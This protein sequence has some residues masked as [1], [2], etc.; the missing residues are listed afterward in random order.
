[1]NV[2]FFLYSSCIFLLA[3]FLFMVLVWRYGLRRTLAGLGERWGGGPDPDIRSLEKRWV[4]VH[5][6][7]VGEVRAVG[8]FLRRFPE[9]FPGCGRLLTTTTVAGRDLARAENLAES[10]VLAPLDVPWAVERFLTRWSPTALVLVETELWP[11]W[12]RAMAARRLPMLL[13][14]GRISARSFPGYYA[15]RFLWTPLLKR[16]SRIAVQGPRQA[17]RFLRL[18]APADRVVIAGNL[19][20]DVAPPG[21]PRGEALMKRFGFSPGDDV[22]VCGSTHPGEES[23]VA[24]AY[25]ALRRKGRFF[26]VAVA[27]RHV[28]R[29]AEVAALFTDAGWPARLRS[30]P[31]G[32]PSAPVLV[33]DTLGELGDLYGTATVA[34]VGG[35]LVPKGGQNPLEPARW[36]VPVAAGPHMENFEEMVETFDREAALVRLAGVGDLE[37]IVGSLLD[38]PA[39][40]AVLGAAARAAAAA[41]SGAA[42]RHLDLLQEILACPAPSRTTPC[43]C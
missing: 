34:F 36:G 41:Q 21:A 40:R 27:P 39:R 17:S 32:D 6:A 30:R 18:G 33:L 23:A 29:A 16:F 1:M 25:G 14:N 11:Q 43:G 22:W 10:V 12:I 42:A 38:D 7:S 37:N 9:R 15:S 35:S 24:R 26:K 4:W 31:E 8:E 2:F 3:P 19:K 20:V 13:A 28:E 5:A